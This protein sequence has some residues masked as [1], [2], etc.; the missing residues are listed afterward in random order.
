MYAKINFNL[1]DLIGM[2]SVTICDK[3]VTE[4]HDKSIDYFKEFIVNIL[5]DNMESALDMGMRCVNDRSQSNGSS[6]KTPKNDCAFAEH[7]DDDSNGNA[8]FLVCSTCKIKKG[9]E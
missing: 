2:F 6:K 1:C 4:T 8:H 9:T 3:K 5:G 7:Y